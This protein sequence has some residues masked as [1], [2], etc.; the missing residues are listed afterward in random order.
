MT[1]SDHL[2][3]GRIALFAAALAATAVLAI[4]SGGLPTAGAAA[5]QCGD[6]GKVENLTANGVSCR[7]AKKVAKA[8]VELCGYT[9]RCAID[10]AS[11][12]E[13]FVCRGDELNARKAKIV[14]TG[15]ESG[16]KIK[17]VG[18]I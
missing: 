6:P 5:D 4:A 11:V 10:N 9:G 12:G 1:K 15:E 3:G 2:P 8:W 7:D 16:A 14:C 17:F 13:Q 18:R